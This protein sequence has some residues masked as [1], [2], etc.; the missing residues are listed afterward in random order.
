MSDKTCHIVPFSGVECMPARN[1]AAAAICP[2]KA[3]Q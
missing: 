1:P 3:A 2:I